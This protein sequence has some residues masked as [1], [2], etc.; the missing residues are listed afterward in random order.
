M[1]QTKKWEDIYYDWKSSGQTQRD[2]CKTKGISF[3][4]FKNQTYK[5]GIS[6]R[7][8][9]FK[10]IEISNATEEK[11][12][13]CEIKFEG[14]NQIIIENRESLMYLKQLIRSVVQS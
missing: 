3:G 12:P 2:Y 8:S 1:K 5:L 7:E 11:H 14:G 4:R 10:A 13:Y 6:G 9:S